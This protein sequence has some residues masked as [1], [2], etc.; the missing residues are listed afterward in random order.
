M[1]K[2]I[3]VFL[4]MLAASGVSAQQPADAAEQFR[5]S[6]HIGVGAFVSARF[7]GEKGGDKWG[8]GLVW[9]YGYAFS[10]YLA[11]DA[12]MVYGNVGHGGGLH[13]SNLGLSAGVVATPMPVAFRY[14][15]VG[16][17]AAWVHRQYYTSIS[18]KFDGRDL[19]GFDAILRLYAIDNL[20]W[21]L[22]ASYQPAFPIIGGKVL[23]NYSSLTLCLGYKF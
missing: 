6:A 19:F 15:K 13:E 10:P 9:G 2:L 18:Q 20:K 21:Q 5:N 7:E 8:G 3:G 14:L 12:S 17:A 22:F 23:F 1:K 4:A 11:L 16:V